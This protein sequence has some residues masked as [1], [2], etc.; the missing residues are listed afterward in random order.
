[1]GKVLILSLFSSF[2]YF[3]FS[4]SF[5]F[6]YFFSLSFSLSYLLSSLSFISFSFYHFF[7][8]EN[9]YNHP[10]LSQILLLLLLSL[11]LLLLLSLLLL[12]LFFVLHPSIHIFV[13][14]EKEKEE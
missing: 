3:F 13:L 10:L 14:P 2:H 1:V 6:S 8:Q 4:L 12:L 11:L 7:I 9:K 5:S